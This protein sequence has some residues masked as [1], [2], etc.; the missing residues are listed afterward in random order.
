[1]DYAAMGD[2]LGAMS[3]RTPRR[4]EQGLPTNNVIIVEMWYRQSQ[5]L[6]FPLISIL[7]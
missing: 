4:G 2:E 6:G 7:Y 5:L 1:M 3:R